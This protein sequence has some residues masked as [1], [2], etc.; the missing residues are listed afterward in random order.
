M[1]CGKDRADGEKVLVANEIAEVKKL[2]NESTAKRIN[3]C[4]MTD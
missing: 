3:C 2:K 4:V 1:G